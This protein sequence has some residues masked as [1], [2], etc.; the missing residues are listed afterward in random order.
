MS[1]LTKWELGSKAYALMTAAAD[2]ARDIDFEVIGKVVIKVIEIELSPEYAGSG[3]GPRKITAL[4]AWFGE[5]WPRYSYQVGA[6]RS[7][8]SALVTVLNLVRVFRA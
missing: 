8:V 2:F 4:V 7:F 5:T 1:W 6:L 3:Q